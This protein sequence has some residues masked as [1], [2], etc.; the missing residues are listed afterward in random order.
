MSRPAASTRMRS[1]ARTVLSRCAMTSVVRPAAAASSAACTAASD[2]A[3]SADVAS[4][5]SSTG[6]SCSTARAMASRCFWPPLSRTP[7][8]PICVWYPSGRAAT[9]PSALAIA[10]AAA[11]SAGTASPRRH[12]RQRSS[13]SD[14]PGWLHSEYAMFSS[15]VPEKSTGSWPTRPTL[16]CSQRW[17]SLRTSWPSRSTAPPVAS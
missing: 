11:T 5:N 4:S 17:S 3:S 7:F 1:A 6:G 2:S 13:N 15:T 9:N 10:A 14:F 8:S 12:A 16:R